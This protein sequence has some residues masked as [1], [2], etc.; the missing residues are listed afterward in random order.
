MSDQDRE[1]AN[2]LERLRSAYIAQNE[3]LADLETAQAKYRDTIHEMRFASY[4]DAIEWLTR[5][6]AMRTE[7]QTP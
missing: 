5:Y 1:L 4:K 7:K 3:L 2:K 6:N